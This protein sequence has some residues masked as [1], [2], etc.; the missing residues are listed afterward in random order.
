MVMQQKVSYC[1]IPHNCPIIV[2]VFRV[3]TSDQGGEFHNDLD[4]RLMEMLGVFN[5]GFLL[6]TT[7]RYNYEFYT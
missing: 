4:D 3:I 1:T 5:I 7:R 2:Q 6:L